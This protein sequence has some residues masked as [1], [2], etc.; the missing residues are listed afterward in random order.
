MCSDD[1]NCRKCQVQKSSN[2][3]RHGTREN[4]KENAPQKTWMAKMNR[5][6][7]RDNMWIGLFPLS[8]IL[9]LFTWILH[10]QNLYIYIWYLSSFCVSMTNRCFIFSFVCIHWLGPETQLYRFSISGMRYS[11]AKW[12]ND[13]TF[14]NN[15][16]E[17]KRVNYLCGKS[18]W[19]KTRYV[20]ITD[21]HKH[22]VTFSMNCDDSSS[23]HS[24]GSSFWPQTFST[25]FDVLSTAH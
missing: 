2:S 12:F 6:R 19:G 10:L 1:R 25:F 21:T 17:K 16:Q 5:T 22:I 14:F 4:E 8:C 24:S 11:C 15:F 18:L 9:G 13:D 23:S 20:Q 7:R 3:G